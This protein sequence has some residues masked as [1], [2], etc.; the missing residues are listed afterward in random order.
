MALEAT[1]GDLA[2]TGE[3]KAAQLVRIVA[4]LQE[5]REKWALLEKWVGAV[6]A[7]GQGRWRQYEDQPGS[8]GEKA[9]EARATTRHPSGEPVDNAEAKEA[10]RQLVKSYTEVANRSGPGAKAPAGTPGA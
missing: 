10:G 3:A 6:G 7:D 4:E 9:L 5:A 1:V 2:R 8:E